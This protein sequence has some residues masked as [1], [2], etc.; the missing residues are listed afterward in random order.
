MN[1]PK[2]FLLALMLTSISLTAC[3]WERPEDNSSDTLKNS[4]IQSSDS[5]GKDGEDEV[6]EE[7]PYSQGPKELPVQE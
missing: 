6:E 2:L 1:T 3:F 4:L 7:V 5:Q